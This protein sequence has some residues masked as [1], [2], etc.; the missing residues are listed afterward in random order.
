M[1]WYDPIFLRVLPPAAALLIKAL[2][3]SCR[4]VTVRG[5]D[6]AREALARSGGAASYATWHQRMAYL[7]HHFGTRHVSVMISRSR[8][9]EYAA[10]VAAW[11]G[12]RSVRGSSTRGGRR[13]LV[14]M[15][16]QVRDGERAGFLADGPQGPPRVAKM[17][18]L[19]VAR[20]AQVPLIAVLWGAD[21]CWVLDSWDRYLVP[22]PF[23]RVAVLYT[24]PIWIPPETKDDQLESY[25]QLLESRMNEGARWCDEQFGP[26]RPW[27]KVVSPGTP[28]IG[29]LDGET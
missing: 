22:K 21:R 15:I 12:F 7:F 8:D 2:M 24:E 25:R 10:R 29:P 19:V 23:A 28:E 20:D 27:R 16:R 26:E 18:A 17:G 11:L 13:A 3:I 14:D 5:E 9:G 6:S 1:R 4:G